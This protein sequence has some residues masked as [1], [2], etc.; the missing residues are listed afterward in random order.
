MIEPRVWRIFFSVVAVVLAWNV[1]TA[2]PWRG[3]VVA[4]GPSGVFT[5]GEKLEIRASGGMGVRE[6][7]VARVVNTWLQC[8][9]RPLDWWNT[10][11]IVQVIR[12]GGSGQPPR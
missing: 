6:C 7:T 1:W 4:Q 5:I 10:Q 3:G 8:Q 12:L 11:Q 2:R 9:E